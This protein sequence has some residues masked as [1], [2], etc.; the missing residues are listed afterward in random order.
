MEGERGTTPAAQPDT[1]P[2][3]EKR[4]IEAEILRHVHDTLTERFGPE[5]ADAVVAEA[6]RRSALEQA[7]RFAAAAGSTSLDSFVAAQE[8]WTRDGA[9]EIAV[10][11]RTADTYAFDVVRCRYAETYRSMGLGRIGHLLSCNRDG[12]F[13]KGYDPKLRLT[14]T[15]TIMQGASHCDFRYR[16]ADEGGADEA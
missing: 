14:R 10:R 2:I 3:L 16:Y 11:E 1:L 13:C 4:K 8:L 15:Q 12:V 5:T 7:G 9:L 6:V